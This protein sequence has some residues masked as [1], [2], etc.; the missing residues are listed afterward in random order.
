MLQ[1]LVQP[2]VM[3]LCCIMLLNIDSSCKLSFRSTTY[4]WVLA[5]SIHLLLHQSFFSYSSIIRCFKGTG[6][7]AGQGQDKTFH[8]ARG[9][10]G[11]HVMTLSQAEMFTSKIAL[12]LG[13]SASQLSGILSH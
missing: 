7:P 6:V 12:I 8:Q 2:G 10:K 4:N 11:H 1:S 9:L 5:D 3:A 13:H